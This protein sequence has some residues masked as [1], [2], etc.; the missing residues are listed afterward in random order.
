[1][2]TEAQPERIALGRDL[3]PLVV[4]VIAIAGFVG[5]WLLSDHGLFQTIVAAIAM[6]G[7]AAVALL[8]PRR[9]VAAVGVTFGLAVFSRVVLE[10]QAGTMRIEQPALLALVVAAAWY[11]NRLDLPS[12]RGLWPLAA[13][14]LIYLGVLALSSAFVADQPFESLK[15]VAWSALSMAGGAVTALLVS[16]R[17]SELLPWYSGAAAVTA[18]IGLIAGVL[19]LLLGIGPPLITGFDTGIPKVNALVYEPNLYASLLA[20]AIPLALELWRE[21]PRWGTAAVASV[22]LVA[23][24]LGVTRGAYIGLACGLVVYFGLLI[25]RAGLDRRIRTLAVIVALA[26]AVGLA[27]PLL[28][29]NVNMAG[30]LVPEAQRPAAGGG[31]VAPPDDELQTL[32]YRLDQVRTG[33]EDLKESPLIGMGAYSYGQ[34]HSEPSGM[35]GPAVIAVWPLSVVHDAGV[36]GLLALSAFFVLLGVRLWRATRDKLLLGPAAAFG[37][38]VAVLLVAYLATTALHFAVTWLIIGAALAATLKRD[39][40][41]A[42]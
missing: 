34:R 5:L 26:G 9:P 40:E 20:A 10:L 39:A 29:L 36:V 17:V 1:M 15:L 16:G 8:V 25:W 32:D 27:A 38:S 22:L 6:A 4:G 30:I 31:V 7:A 11:R 12:I 42:V 13:T 23:L 37:A 3:A 14:A 35:R 19:Y 2:A 41:A 21:R 24:G 18:A 33:L 28:L